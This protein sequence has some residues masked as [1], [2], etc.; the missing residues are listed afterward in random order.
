MDGNDLVKRAKSS[1]AG[2]R[3]GICWMTSGN[4]AQGTSG[5]IGLSWVQGWIIHTVGGKAEY[6]GTDVRWWVDV[7]RRIWNLFGYVF[8][9]MSLAEPKAGGGGVGR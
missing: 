5:G 4:G 7:G 9:A 8:P 6:V 2:D 1:D 3:E